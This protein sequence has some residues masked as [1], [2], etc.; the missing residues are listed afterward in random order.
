M[1]AAAFPIV[2]TTWAVIAAR[3]GLCEPHKHRGNADGECAGRGG[4]ALRSAAADLLVITPRHCEDL[5]QP[6][7]VHARGA[8]PYPACRARPRERLGGRARRRRRLDRPWTFRLRPAARTRSAKRSPRSCAVTPSP[9][10]STRPSS[11]RR[12]KRG[13]PAQVASSPRRS[14]TSRPRA[15]GVGAANGRRLVTDEGQRD[16]HR[17]AH[18]RAVADRPPRHER[19]DVGSRRRRPDRD[20]APRRAS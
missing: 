9:D 2:S 7:A 4:G 15:A 11:T 20:L 8:R 14:E 18:D 16:R 3:C 10:G 17:G 12:G 19:G 6:D 1:C 13:G 5:C